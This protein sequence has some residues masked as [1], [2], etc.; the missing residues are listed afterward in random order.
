MNNEI[1]IANKFCY[2]GYIVSIKPIGA[3]HIN[4]TY[5]VETTKEKYT[6]QLINTSIF[7]DPEGLMQNIFNVTEFLKEKIKSRGGDIKRET[8]SVVKTKDGCLF[9]KDKENFYWRSYIYR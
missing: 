6:L 7:K 1:N 2:D 3:G 9:Y 5:L 4:K 8:L